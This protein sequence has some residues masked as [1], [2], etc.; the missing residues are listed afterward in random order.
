MPKGV[1]NKKIRMEIWLSKSTIR[2]IDH[3]LT[4]END[5]I[6]SATERIIEERVKVSRARVKGLLKTKIVRA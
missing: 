1:N 4:R 6:K 2:W 3:A 5:S